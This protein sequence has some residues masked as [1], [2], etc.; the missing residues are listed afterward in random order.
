[1][2]LCMDFELIVLQV[3]RR[4]FSHIS[5]RFLPTGNAFVLA[6]R[7]YRQSGLVFSPWFDSLADLESFAKKY[8]VDILHDRTIGN[9]N[10]SSLR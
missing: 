6:S 5:K 10:Q 9:I 4:A 8:H 3:Q 7:D 1:M 2:R